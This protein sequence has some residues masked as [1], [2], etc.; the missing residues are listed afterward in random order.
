MNN[1]LP[2]P[3]QPYRPRFFFQLV[4]K[5]EWLLQFGCPDDVN[6]WQS[7]PDVECYYKV[8][9]STQV[10]VKK[11]FWLHRLNSYNKHDYNINSN[12]WCYNIIWVG[13]D[14]PHTPP[15]NPTGSLPTIYVHWQ[16]G[17]VGRSRREKK[18]TDLKSI[19]RDICTVNAPTSNRILGWE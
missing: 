17:Q 2:P 7:I 3:S 12:R 18:T 13:R 8:I 11:Y 16:G 10:V 5:E 6:D 19:L 4:I 14:E 15:V 1:R 9:E